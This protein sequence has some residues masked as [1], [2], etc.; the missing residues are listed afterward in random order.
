MH[1]KTCPLKSLHSS[2]PTDAHNIIPFDM[3]I[4]SRKSFRTHYSKPPLFVHKVS[5]GKVSKGKLSEG[6][7]YEGK[8][9]KG[10]VYEG[11]VYEGKVSEGK[12]SERKVYEGKVLLVEFLD[13]N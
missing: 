3:F 4:F 9:F 2:A 5:E 12:M 6:K 13:K 7:V 11:K 8:V 1:Q 10:K